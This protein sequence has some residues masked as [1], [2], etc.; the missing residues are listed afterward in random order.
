[1]RLT[2][3]IVGILIGNLACLFPLANPTVTLSQS[4]ALAGVPTGDDPFSWLEEVASE[5]ALAWV[6]EQN[7]ASVRELEAA[8]G[9]DL[10]RQR[11]L[12]IYESRERIPNVTKQGNYY[13]NFWRDDR[14]VR[15]VWRRTTLDEYRK[16]NPAWETVIDLDELAALEQENWLWKSADI[17]RPSH[18]R[19]LIFL[20]R[21]GADATV[22]REF[23]LNAKRFVTDGFT[24][25]EAKSRVAW[26]HRDAIYVG[27]DF[28]V[29][30]LTRSGYP[31]IVKEWRRGTTIEEAI[32]VFEGQTEDV[33]VAAAVVHDVSRGGGDAERTRTIGGSGHP[34]EG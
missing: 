9:F 5:R 6:Q 22:M 3:T 12:S 11:L 16:D 24:L 8:A 25:P 20:S 13:Y 4:S 21:G 27:T 15:G 19:A 1:M 17:L 34:T 2:T 10:L 28:G 32:T 29:G 23:D 31:R 30:S 7:H 18:D 14:R 33:S 26:R